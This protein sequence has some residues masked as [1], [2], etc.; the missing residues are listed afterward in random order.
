MGLAICLSI[1]LEKNINKQAPGGIFG[2]GHCDVLG[3]T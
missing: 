3:E 2:A 1:K